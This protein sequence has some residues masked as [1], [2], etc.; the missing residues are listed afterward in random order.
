MDVSQNHNP[1]NYP[2]RIQSPQSYR[3]DEIKSQRSQIY[4]H[5]QHSWANPPDRR[6]HPFLH[7]WVHE[8]FTTQM[9]EPI[10]PNSEIPLPNTHSPKKPKSKITNHKTKIKKEKHPFDPSLTK[11]STTHTHAQSFKIYKGKHKR[12]NEK[13]NPKTKIQTFISPQTKTLKWVFHMNGKKPTLQYYQ[14]ISSNLHSQKHHLLHEHL[15]D[16]KRGRRKKKRE[17]K[18]HMS[19]RKWKIDLG[20]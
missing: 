16:E 11:S 1:Q 4:P 14:S 3:I 10:N 12:G 15:A 19:V 6:V 5:L 17:R 2:R 7:S 9:S 13:Q 20:F 18:T 8:P